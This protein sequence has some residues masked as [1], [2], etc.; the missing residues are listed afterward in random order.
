MAKNSKNGPTRRKTRKRKY[1]IPNKKT[2]RGM[3]KK[4]H[5][6]KK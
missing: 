6:K 5:R 2:K 3:K 1:V 4:R